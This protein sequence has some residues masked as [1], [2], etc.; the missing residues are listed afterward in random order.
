VVW[1]VHSFGGFVHR[2]VVVVHRGRWGLRGHLGV[3]PTRVRSQVRAEHLEP[4]EEVGRV[5][6]AVVGVAAGVAVAAAAADFGD[7]APVA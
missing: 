2:G 4:V 1:V 3:W 7:E 5:G 6:E